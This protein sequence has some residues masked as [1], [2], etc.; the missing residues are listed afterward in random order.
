MR[1]VKLKNLETAQEATLEVKCVF[2]AI[3][4]TPNTAVFWSKLATDKSGYLLKKDGSLM[5]VPGVF[6]AGDVLDPYYP[7]AVTAAG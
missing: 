5:D 7:Q 3:G 1:A 4:H 6:A 2:I